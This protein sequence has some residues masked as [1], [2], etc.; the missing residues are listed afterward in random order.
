MA[1]LSTI[2]RPYAE[3]AFDL[4]REKN[5]LP[6]WSRMLE[7]VAAVATDARMSEA[8][9]SPKL[10]DAEKESL[11]LSVC[12][13]KLDADARSFVRVLI[14]SDRIGVAREIREIYEK[15]RNDA[16]GVA[17]AV[18]ES[19][20]PVSDADLKGLVTALERR[21]GRKVEA[22]VRVNPDLIGGARITVGDT[23]IDDSV[24]GKLTAMAT[25]LTA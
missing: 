3:A 18:I 5:A 24:Q 21:F 20:L 11:F 19:A 16:E 14:E 15:R 7:L 25:Q 4:A 13:D 8:L 22:I 23:V 17:R 10:G 6:V 2:A 12:G 9:A 1:E